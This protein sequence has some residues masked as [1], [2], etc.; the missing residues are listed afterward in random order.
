MMTSSNGNI[1]RD[2]G[3]LCGE[4]TGPRCIPRTKA[5]DTELWW[6]FFYQRLNKRLSKQSWGWWFETSSWPLWRHCNG[7]MPLWAELRFYLKCVDFRPGL[8]PWVAAWSLMLCWWPL[9]DSWGMNY[10]SKCKMLLFWST[11]CWL[12]PGWFVMLWMCVCCV[13]CVN[14]WVT[15]EYTDYVNTL[16]ISM[17]I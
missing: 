10:D 9:A 5:S 3:H 14:E 2:T 13:C 4:F 6:V 12:N 7:V 11:D 1:F 16:L 8:A 15:N 17:L